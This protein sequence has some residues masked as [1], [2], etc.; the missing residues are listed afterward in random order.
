LWLNVGFLQLE[1]RWNP[2]NDRHYPFGVGF[3]GGRDFE[4]SAKGGT[5]H[6]LEFTAKGMK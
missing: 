4:Q 1:L 2:V 5:G 6:V 3:P